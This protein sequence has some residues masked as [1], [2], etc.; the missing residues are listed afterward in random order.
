MAM[1]ASEELLTIAELAIAIAGFSGVV[2]A[3]GHRGELT[4]VDRWRF[5][6]LLAISMGAAVLAFLPSVLHLLGISGSFLWRVSSAMY[7]GISVAHLIIFVPRLLRT[8]REFD[9]TPPR[10]FLLVSFL[11]VAL[12]LSLQLL[13]VVGWPYPP[14]AAFLT[15]GLIIWLVLAALNFGSLVIGPR[16]R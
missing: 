13:N 15:S 7:L 14:N 5:A 6:S 9:V 11:L 2:V 4:P 10:A 16:P 3:F 12:N 8:G 1:Q